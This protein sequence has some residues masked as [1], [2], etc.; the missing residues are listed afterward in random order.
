MLIIMVLLVEVDDVRLFVVTH[1]ASCIRNVELHEQLW[2]RKLR[3]VHLQLA[4]VN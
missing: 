1:S 4:G 2:E 3:L